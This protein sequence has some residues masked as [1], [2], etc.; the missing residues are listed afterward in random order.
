MPTL[1][2][3]P[4]E[5]GS[6]R[7][8]DRLSSAA[9]AGAGGAVAEGVLKRTVCKQTKIDSTQLSQHAQGAAGMQSTP[10]SHTANTWQ[11]RPRSADNKAKVN[12]QQRPAE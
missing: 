1:P 5:D 3:C 7:G 9:A 2:T 12:N 11:R 4:E 10:V 8:T 6:L